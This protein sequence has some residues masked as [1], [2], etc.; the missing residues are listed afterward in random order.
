MKFLID[1]LGRSAHFLFTNFDVWWLVLYKNNFRYYCKI[2]SSEGPP[3]YCTFF[4][5]NVFKEIYYSSLN[6]VV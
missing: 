3:P 2:K 6:S 1:E 5:S 4:Y